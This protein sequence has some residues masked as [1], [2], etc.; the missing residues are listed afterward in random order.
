MEFPVD[1]L[2]TVD[3]KALEESAET[4]FSQLHRNPDIYESLRLPD[5]REVETG[6]NVCFMPLFGGDSKGK[7]LA[8]LSPGEK[9]LG[10]YLRDQWWSTEDILKTSD[11]SRKGLLEV[12]T[13]VERI[14]LYVLNR[15]IYRMKEK[16]NNDVIFPL[17]EEDEVAKILWKDGEAVGFYSVKTKDSLCRKFITE[18]YQLPVMDAIFIRKYFRGHGYGLQMLEDYV[19]SFRNDYV[20]LKYPLSPAMYKVCKKYLSTYSGNKELLWEVQDTGARSD[21][22][23]IARKLE[24]MEL[25]GDHQVVRNLNFEAENTD[26]PLETVNTQEQETRKYTEEVV[27]EVVQIKKRK[28]K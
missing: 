19:S 16:A 26:V 4:I 17:H 21:R 11:P 6:C 22:T 14:V 24:T 28:G 15:I 5:S 8:L 23:L 12:R 25:K 10:L 18:C 1:L 9:V 13:P 2:A 27:D 20:G 3:L 7:V